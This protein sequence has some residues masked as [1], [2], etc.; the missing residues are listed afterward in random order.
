MG[1]TIATALD[2]GLAINQSVRIINSGIAGVL[3]VDLHRVDLAAGDVLTLGVSDAV[4]YTFVRIF[5]ATGAQV[6][7][8]VQ[9]NPGSANGLLRFNAPATGSYYVGLSGYANTSYNPNQPNSG[10]NASYTG[11][12]TP[13]AWSGSVRA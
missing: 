12:T 7:A 9:F 1:D 2:T 8:P 3:D 11:A 4:P 5:D 13:S 6:Q 10:N